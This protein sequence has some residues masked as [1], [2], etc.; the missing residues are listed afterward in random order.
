M[1]KLEFVR[2]TKKSARGRVGLLG[3][4]G[5]GKTF[6]ALKIATM[7][8]D[9]IEKRTG[10][11]PSIRMI[12]SERGSGAKYSGQEVDLKEGKFVFDHLELEEF[13]PQTYIEAMQVAADAGATG[14][15]LIID[16]LSHAW[17]GKGGALE[18]KESA[19]KRSK[20]NDWAAWREITP[21]HN[22]LVDAMLQHPHHV[23]ATMRVKTEWV[24]EEKDGKK[25]PRK[26]G[27]QPQQRDGMEYE[28]DVVG[29]IDL[30][31]DWAISKTR[32]PTLDQKVLK[33]PGSNFAQP[34]V[35]WLSD[36]AVEPAPKAASPA[37]APAPTA[38]TNPALAA[39]TSTNT[40][41]ASSSKEDTSPVPPSAPATPPPTNKEAQRAAGFEPTPDALGVDAPK[42]ARDATVRMAKAPEDDEAMRLARL[43][44]EASSVKELSRIPGLVKAA[45]E[46][47]QIDRAQY[48]DLLKA[49]KTLK[50]A[51]QA[52]EGAAT[53]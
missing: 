49:Y 41:A 34:F 53:P 28:F 20:G 21:L 5:S 43:I 17:M 16:S 37:A 10:K 46:K 45:V 47:K 48:D 19:A 30:E 13:A 14:D 42:K 36:G 32:C 3:P 35:A 50:Q 38:A 39:S 12:D 22:A 4:S 24:V 52:K 29:E 23:I 6:S 33:K 18:Q 27:M 2:A 44:V 25:T 1:A 7:M 40:P 31:H 26:I 15:I 11:R 8:A 9:E 51:L